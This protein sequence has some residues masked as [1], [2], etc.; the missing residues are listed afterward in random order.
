VDLTRAEA[1]DLEPVAG[2]SWLIVHNAR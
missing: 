2:T 1:R